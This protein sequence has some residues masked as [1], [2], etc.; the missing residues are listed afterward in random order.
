MSK[1]AGNPDKNETDSI[2]TDRDRDR[3]PIDT[4]DERAQS[5]A[6]RIDKAY[7]DNG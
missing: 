6:A 7:G 2:L 1:H 3:I 4:S 5:D